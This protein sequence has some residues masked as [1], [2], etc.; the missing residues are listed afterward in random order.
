MKKTFV[1]ILAVLAA[2]FSTADAQ[3]YEAINTLQ[4]VLSPALSGSGR[5]KGS[6]EAGYAHTIGS[7]YNADFVS[8]STSQ[9]YQ[10]NNWFYM[11]AGLGVDLLMS[12]KGSQ[13]NEGLIT[14]PPY[15]RGY[16]TT[17][18][19]LPLFADF[20]FLIGDTSNI[21]FNL[22]LKVGCSFL[23]S[24]KMI[25]IG[26]GYLT[27]REYF[28]LEP[29]IGV[30]VPCNKKNPKQAFNV[31]VKYKLLTSNYWYNYNNN[32]TLQGLGAFVAYEW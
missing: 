32:I 10:Y 25:A 16:A 6:V 1:S 7:K 19:M 11:G 15:N 18:A 24:N 3:I 21:A 29:A 4:S 9:G 28:F 13:W 31:G 14:P 26:N 30:R 17:A 12:H 5:Y 27:N 22:D 2:M 8:V 23:M 20:R